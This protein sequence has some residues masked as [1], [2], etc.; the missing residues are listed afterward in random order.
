MKGKSE[1]PPEL[2]VQAHGSLFML[3]ENV[4]N[5]AAPPSRKRFGGLRKCPSKPE[6]AKTG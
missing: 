4:E 5:S 1:K 6:R 3:K 2:H